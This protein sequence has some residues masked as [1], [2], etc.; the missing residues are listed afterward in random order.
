MEFIALGK[1]NLLVS[2]TAFGAMSLDC[3][4]IQA[5][6]DG[7]EE[8][9]CTIV[10]AAYDSGIN[11]FDVSHANPLCE[12]RL[13]IALNEIRQNVFLSTKSNAQTVSD[14]RQDLQDC[15]FNLGTDMLDLFFF[16]SLAIVPGKKTPDGLYNE[17]VRQKEK[18]VIRHIG[19]CTEDPELAVE[20]SECGLYEVVQ[21]PFNALTDEQS[22]KVVQSCMKNEVGFI[23]SQPLCGGLVDNIPLAYGFFMQYENVVPVWGIHTMEQLRQIVYF[24]EHPPVI[25]ERFNKELEKMRAFFN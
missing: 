6:G 5:L 21:F 18:G 9:V 11:F 13:G 7:A 19:F 17:A 3:R 23:A 14:L 15:L 1:T 16:D 24:N 25:D 4:E 20:A 8:E 2:R 22:R 12:K 10:K